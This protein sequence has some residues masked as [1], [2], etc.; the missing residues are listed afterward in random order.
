MDQWQCIGQKKCGRNGPN[1]WAKEMGKEMHKKMEQ[2]AKLSGAMTRQ[3]AK[4]GGAMENQRATSG[5]AMG[6]KIKGNVGWSNGG[7]RST[8]KQ[9]WTK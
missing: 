8:H 4:L 2:W 5:G 3:V 7:L 1:Q 6:K 9:G